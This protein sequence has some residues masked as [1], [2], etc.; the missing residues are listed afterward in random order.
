M[1]LNYPVLILLFVSTICFSQIPEAIKKPQMKFLGAF[2]AGQP[3][4]S[5]VKLFDQTDDVL[6]YVLMPDSA[7][8]RQGDK[9]KWVYE[10]NSVGSISCLKVKLAVT[11][12]QQGN[13]KM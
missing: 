12:I 7:G 5:I 3:D 13:S 9:G 1:K 4:V 2:D 6:C 11:P 8:R 10:G